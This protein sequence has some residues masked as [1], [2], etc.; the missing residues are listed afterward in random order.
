MRL[1]ISS[2]AYTWAI[3]VPGS[4]PS[5]PMNCFKLLQKAID[6]G[7]SCVQ[8]A[9]NLPLHKLDPQSRYQLLQMVQQNHIGIEVGMRGMTAD[10]MIK[11]IDL[12]EYFRSP[13]LRTVIDIGDY[14]PGLEEIIFVIKDYLPEL[15]ARNI[16]LAIENHDRLKASEFARIIESIGDDHVGICLDSVNSMGAGEGLEEVLR[17]LG[18]YTINFHIKDYR[19]RRQSHMMGF[20]IEGTPAGEGMLPIEDIIEKLDRWGDCNSG[21]LEL[22]TPPGK[23]VDETIDIENSWVEQ[24]IRFLKPLF[25]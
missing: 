3:G 15:T 11:Y 12:A 10:N 16:N 18:P 22:W 13:I 4:I 24:S 14:K 2:Y 9:D 5:N 1:G 19:V 8:I 6:L 17:V 23:N 7:L 25:D 21:I 20:V